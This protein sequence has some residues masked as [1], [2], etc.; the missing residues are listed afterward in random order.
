MIEEV[1]LMGAC[2]KNDALADKIARYNTSHPRSS[3]GDFFGAPKPNKW[4][5][6]DEK[7]ANYLVK[8]N[9]YTWRCV[10]YSEETYTE[11]YKLYVKFERQRFYIEDEV[12]LALRALPLEVTLSPYAT[13]SAYRKFAP[14]QVWGNVKCKHAVNIASSML[15]KAGS[16]YPLT[17]ES[18]AA[19]IAIETAKRA[20]KLPP[21][22]EKVLADVRPY[23]SLADLKRK[24]AERT[25][26]PL[27][28][29]PKAPLKVTGE[30]L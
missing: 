15:D 28:V 3:I 27:G 26:L 10:Y 18:R 12:L 21:S 5:G 29:A 6:V 7:L 13:I 20:P 9:N 22:V 14:T 24:R 30:V 23:Y 8:L 11:P 1:R 2:R 19:H 4:K 17:K 25:S 16:N